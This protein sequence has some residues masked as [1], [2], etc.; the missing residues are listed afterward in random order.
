[1]K[2]YSKQ[3]LGLEAEFTSFEKAAVVLVPFPYEGGVSYGLGTAKAPDAILDAS[4]Y[5]E[6]YD[7]V[8]DD[9]PYRIGITTVNPPKIANNPADMIQT[10]YETTLFF[11]NQ[12]KFVILIG[13]DHSITFGYFKAIKE[14]YGQ[15]S[16]I[17]LDA[18]AD[19]RNTYEGSPWSHACVMSRIR[20][21]TAHTLQ[22]GIRSLSAKEAA[23]V[24]K[25]NI[26]L[27]TMHQFRQRRFDLEAALNLLPDPVFL[28]V[29][30][31]VFD[32]SVIMST[33]TP[34]PGGLLWDE[35]VSL[36]QK[37]F[38]QK[39]VIGF[40][41][42]ELSYQENDRNSPYAAAKMIYKMIGFKFFINKNITD[43]EL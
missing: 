9:Q 7:E 12:D 34:E 11:L 40:D 4:C 22:I 19:L 14:K 17:Q 23:L 27:C 5:L 15:V 24:K 21:I 36:L 42:V 2:L 25:E 41:F 29:D 10:I 35:G 18:H 30:A 26:S 37:I 38:M 16:V 1:M 6:L 13:G 20:E 3:F 33:G 28:T 32:W 31:D 39:N 8:L 43:L